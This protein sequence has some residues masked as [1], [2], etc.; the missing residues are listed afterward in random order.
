MN[1]RR[2]TA[3]LHDLWLL[4]FRWLA[5]RAEDPVAALRQCAADAPKVWRAVE[6]DAAYAYFAADTLRE[7]FARAP[8]GSGLTRLACTADLPGASHG[9]DAPFHYVVETDVVAEH[10]ADFNAWYDKEHL[11][12]LAA[13]PGTVRAAR[14]VCRDSSPRYYACYDFAWQEAFGSPAWLA[15]RATDWSSRVRPSFRNTARTMFRRA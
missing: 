15:V 10:E 4:K 13:V 11:P 1:A 8:E 9:A 6:G 5:A 3:S 2:G 12:G 7:A 14:Y